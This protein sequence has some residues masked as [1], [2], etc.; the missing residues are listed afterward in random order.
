LIKLSK[1]GSLWTNSTLENEIE[2]LIDFV[3]YNLDYTDDIITYNL[4]I[5]EKTNSTITVLA[6]ENRNVEDYFSSVKLKICE[7]DKKIQLQPKERYQYKLNY[8]I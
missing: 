5:S 7:I 3:K 6:K 8:T 1:R 2:D 4:K